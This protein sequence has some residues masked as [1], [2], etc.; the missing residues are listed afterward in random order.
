MKNRTA[1]ITAEVKKPLK[2][3]FI[4][5]SLLPVFPAFTKY[6]P[7]MEESTPI[8]RTIKGKM[9]HSR[10]P[11]ACQRAKPRIKPETMVTS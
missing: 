4:A 7:T 6:V 2:I 10:R 8:P 9:I 11:V 5:S 3:A 1:E